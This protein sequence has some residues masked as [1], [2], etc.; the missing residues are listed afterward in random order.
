[1]AAPHGV[2][3]KDLKCDFTDHT[4]AQAHRDSQVEF[5]NHDVPV[6]ELDVGRISDALHGSLDPSILSI[7]QEKMLTDSVESEASLLSALTE[8]L[9]SV[10][11]ETL[12]PFD[13]LPDT[14]IFAAQKGSDHT[15]RN[16]LHLSQTSPDRPKISQSP[17]AK[18]GREV[19]MSDRQ[20]RPRRHSVTQITQRDEREKERRS[21]RTFRIESDPIFPQDGRE[22]LA[23]LVRHMHPYCVRTH[24]EKETRV[25]AE[26]EEEFVDV[27]GYEEHMLDQSGHG[28]DLK[29]KAEPNAQNTDSQEEKVTSLGRNVKMTPKRSALVKTSGVKMRVKKTVTFAF[30]LISVHEIPPDDEEISESTSCK[31]DITSSQKPKALSLDQYRLLRQNK[32][33]PEEKRMDFRTKWPSLPRELPPILPKLDPNTPSGE[34]LP[35]VKVKTQPQGITRPS[36]KDGRKAVEL[37][38]DPPNPVLV[39]LKPTR[40]IN[41]TQTASEPL[42]SDSKP[43]V[44]VSCEEVRLSEVVPVT[45]ASK[46]RTGQQNQTAC[47]GVIGE[48]T[49]RL[50]EKDMAMFRDNNRFARQLK[51]FQSRVSFRLLKPYKN[52]VLLETLPGQ[53]FSF[54]NIYETTVVYHGI[55]AADLTSL[56]EQ[57]ETQ[58][59]TP[60]ATPPHQIWRPLASVK[61]TKH[62]SIKPSPSK[63]IQIIEPRPL[64]PSKT[65][66]KPSLPTFTPAMNPARAF[67]DHDYCGIQGSETCFAHTNSLSGSVLLSPDSSPCRMEAFEEAESLRGRG[68]RFSS[69]SLSPLDRGR[70]KRRAY[71]CGYRRSSSRSC[72]SCSSSSSSS[73][74]SMSRSPPRT[75][76]SGSGSRSP[77]PDWRWTSRREK[78]LNRRHEE[79]RKLRQQKAI[80]ERRVVYVGGIRGSMSPSDLKD[81]FSLFGKVEDCTVHLRSHGDNY[82]FVTYHS[83]DDAYAAIESG[84]KLRRPD[85]LP[86]DIC[87]GGRRQFCKSN[88][89]DL[90][91]SRDAAPTS[92]SRCESFDFDALLKQAQ[93]GLKS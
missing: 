15:L 54:H 75:R 63:A 14:E 1:M 83:T 67:L 36:R 41:A 85:E 48:Q 84:G 62:E 3:P 47:D 19:V 42:G 52:I 24:L 78:E 81:R 20:L 32:Q 86:F 21:V 74:R 60:P 5:G 70:L 56:L 90:D 73:S 30:N 9:D 66:S 2:K 38:I 80:E 76:T 7:F 71:E 40:R 22:L 87:F 6:F 18:S 89:A 58:G 27:E 4:A 34:I 43:D 17:A 12:S 68:L 82:G 64:P 13:T 65:H 57:F 53:H 35:A 72:S 26:E 16:L 46:P 92:R 11:V 45:S 61:G 49:V 44:C 50:V 59:L 69:R 91:S 8:M 39:P 10:D 55:E 29:P 77:E 33:P 88:Y 28:P 25:S 31:T 79:A 51:C 93:R 23:D 37:C